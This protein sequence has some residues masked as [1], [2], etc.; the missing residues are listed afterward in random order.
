MISGE[1]GDSPEF[2]FWVGAE[3]RSGDFLPNQ[4][5]RVELLKSASTSTTLST[6]RQIPAAA[7]Q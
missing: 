1:L 6:T 7:G 3:N 5:V 2:Y 4:S